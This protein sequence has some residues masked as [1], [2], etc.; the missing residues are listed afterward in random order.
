MS[1]GVLTGILEDRIRFQHNPG[2]RGSLLRPDLKTALKDNYNVGE[3]QLK[4]EKSIQ[5]QA[6]LD[7]AV[8]TWQHRVVATEPPCKAAITSSHIH[9]HRSTA[10][11]L[12]GRAQGLEL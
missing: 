1:E 8:A 2:K 7:G 4:A 11:V 6:A 12:C 9:T 5:E 10:P 3:A